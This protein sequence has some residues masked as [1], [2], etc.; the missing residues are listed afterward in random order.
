MVAEIELVI[1]DYH[2]KNKDTEKLQKKSE[3]LTH[4]TST[5]LLQELL[6]QQT[7]ITETSLQTT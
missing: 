1:Q 5:Q 7:G 3:F 6:S 4:N 2:F